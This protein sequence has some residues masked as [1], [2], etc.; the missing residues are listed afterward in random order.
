MSI[1]RI[2]QIIYQLPELII[3]LYYII[4]IILYYIAARDTSGFNIKLCISRKPGV[5]S[6]YLAFHPHIPLR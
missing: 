3:A 2:A 1:T 4:S 6:N 5:F